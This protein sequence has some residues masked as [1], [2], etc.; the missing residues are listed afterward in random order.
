M[1][2]PTQPPPQS[3]CGT[4]P[5]PQSFFTL[6]SNLFPPT[7]PCLGKFSLVGVCAGVNFLEAMRQILSE[8][9]MATSPLQPHWP[10]PPGTPKHACSRAFACAVP[11]TWMALPPA[12][13]LLT[14]PGSVF[15]YHTVREAFP[16]PWYM[17]TPPSACYLPRALPYFLAYRL[18]TFACPCWSA[19]SLL[20]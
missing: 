5:S 3:R 16:I 4:P 6:L 13:C 14:S 12:G 18:R 9:S 15:K 1:S 2:K 11:F 17:V 10:A 8:P 7:P 19:L 20:L